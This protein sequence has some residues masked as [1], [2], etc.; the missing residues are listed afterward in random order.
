MTSRVVVRDRTGRVV[1]DDPVVPPPVVHDHPIH[2]LMVIPCQVHHSDP[3]VVDEYGDHPIAVETTTDAVCYMWQSTRGEADEVEHERW[4]IVFKP[5]TEVDAN[6]SVTVRGV[7]FQVHGNPWPV[8][9][10]VTGFETHIE[11][12]VRRHQ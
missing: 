11:A 8:V 12:T 6:D 9:H 4:Q 5:G 3:G 10:P 2:R 7:L 1:R